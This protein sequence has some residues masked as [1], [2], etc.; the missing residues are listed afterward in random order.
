M[1][2]RTH[3]FGVVDIDPNEYAR[4]TAA[5]V[6]MGGGTLD[7]ARAAGRGARRTI[8]AAAERRRPAR[9]RGGRR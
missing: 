8:K 2:L 4:M 7:E 5:A 9:K 6:R 1:K 3:H